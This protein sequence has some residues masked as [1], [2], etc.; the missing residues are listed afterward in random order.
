MMLTRH[1]SVCPVFVDHFECDWPDASLPLSLGDSISIANVSQ[2]ARE[3]TEVSGLKGVRYA[4]VRDFECEGSERPSENDR[5][6]SALYGLYLG[7]KVIRPTAGVFQVFHYD[8]SQGVPRRPRISRNNRET[9]VS[10]CE[11][12]NTI[13]WNDVKELAKLS[14]S[15]LKSLKT[16]TLPIAQAVQS[17]EI[18]YRAD[19]SN[20]RH[21]LWVIGLDALFTSTEWQNRG[22]EVAVGRIRDFL[23]LDFDIYPEET[24]TGLPS[25]GRLNLEDVLSDVYDLRNNLAHG[26]WPNKPWATKVSRRSA[27]GLDDI[28]YTTVLSEAAS[29][30]LRG[31]LMKILAENQ[32]V[33]M[34]NDKTKM[35]AHF[36]QRDLVRKRKTKGMFP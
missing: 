12:L 30:I 25:L 15:I 32:L 20:V 16:P 18:G 21:L 2:L 9:I 6:E 4:L 28:Y 5:S 36:A 24:P 23:G 29:S 22:T 10:D 8:L 34:F 27:D 35:N 13:R 11:R 17:L 33:E 3:T 7:L 31:C 19:F 1:V 14:P 26:T